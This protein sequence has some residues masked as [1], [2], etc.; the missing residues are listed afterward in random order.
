ML[1]EKYYDED[2]GQLLFE[3]VM[4]LLTPKRKSIADFWKHFNKLTQEK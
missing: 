1:T 3:N 4:E 2:E